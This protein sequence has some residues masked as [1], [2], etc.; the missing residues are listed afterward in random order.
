V[1]VTGINSARDFERTPPSDLEAEKRAVGG[2]LLSADAVADVSAVLAPWDHYL[3]AHQ[4]IHEAILELADAGQPADAVTVGNLL[5]KRGALMKVGGG[6]Y[7][8]EL[9]ASVPTAA[10]AGYYARIVRGHAILRRMIEAGTRIVQLGYEGAGEPEEL[11]E[12]ARKALDDAMASHRVD[13]VQDI[14]DLLIE[15]LDALERQEQRVVTSPW[16]DLNLL[17][18][19]VAPGEM[20]VLAGR[21]GTGKSL[22]ALNWAAEV[23]LRRRQPAV[24]F[25]MEMSRHEVMLR[26]ISAEGRVPLTALL[27]R[28][29]A[30]EHWD[31]VNKAREVIAGSPLVIDDTPGCS[32]AHIRAR[33]RVMARNVPPA[34]VVVDYLQLLTGAARVENRQAEVAGFSRGLKLIAGEYQ[35]PVLAISQL[36][37]ASTHRQDQR[38]RLS[39]L[40]ESGAIEN[41]ASIVILL[42][43]EDTNG[44]ETER[45][46]V[47]DFIV[48]KN[49]NMPPGVASLAFQG[50]YARCMSVAPE[51]TP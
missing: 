45:S 36:N 24:I 41:D 20:D 29:L 2:M 8:H 19:G 44:Q 12:R 6:P 38:P 42:H 1:S 43:R 35:V 37:R 17:I 15:T 39:D 9:I 23:A 32:L 48:E 50:E 31:R 4:V 16:P 28:Q 10:N 27:R 34:L 18:N 51:A 40:R 13:G 3:P 22:V 14:D 26:L 11:A 21:P 33:L 49:R 46:G 47:I 25:T 7:L 30:D 5:A